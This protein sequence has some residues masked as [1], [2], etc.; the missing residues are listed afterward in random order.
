[1]GRHRA[2]RCAQSEVGRAQ[3]Q[4]RGRARAGTREVKLG[5]G[6]HPDGAATSPRPARARSRRAPVTS[7]PSRASAD[8]GNRLHAEAV[9]RGLARAEKTAV[10][11]DGADYNATITHGAFPRRPSTSST[12]YHASER[13][14]DFVK[15]IHP[16]MRCEGPFHQAMLRAPGCGTDR[17]AEPNAC[18]RLCRAAGKRRTRRRAESGSIILLSARNRCV[19]ASLPPL[20]GCSWVRG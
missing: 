3:G 12:L 4:G 2:R 15:D 14:S 13:L 7:A 17:S 6:L 10:L 9:R 19:T 11:S 16:L 1:M 20:R 8:F 5:C 18:G